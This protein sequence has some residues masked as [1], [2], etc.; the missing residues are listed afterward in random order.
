MANLL[1]LASFLLI[2]IGVLGPFAGVISLDA[3]RSALT[4][5]A[6]VALLWAIVALSF[7]RKRPAP[8]AG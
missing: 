8:P 6:G 5:A 3:G 4:A 7:S 1:L 2:V